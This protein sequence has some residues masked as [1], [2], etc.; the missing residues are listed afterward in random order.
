MQMPAQKKRIN[1]K[2]T[3]SIVAPNFNEREPAE[4]YRR[5]RDTM[6]STGEPWELVLV[7]DGSTDGSTDIIHELA[8]KDE[9][10]RPVIFARTLATRSPLP[11]AGTMPAV[12]RS[13]SSTGRTCRILR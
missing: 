2:V 9:R 4:L 12:R 5:V 6:D 11:Q 13:S 10:V 7:D 3:Y 8:K 1:M